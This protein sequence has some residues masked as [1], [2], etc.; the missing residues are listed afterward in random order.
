[1][2]KDVTR[3]GNKVLNHFNDKKQE[4][5]IDDTKLKEYETEVLQAKKVMGNAL[6]ELMLIQKEA[7]KNG[8]TVTI[9]KKSLIVKYL[10]N[11]GLT[12]NHPQCNQTLKSLCSALKNEEENTQQVAT[13]TYVCTLI[14]CEL[15][16]IEDTTTEHLKFSQQAKDVAKGIIWN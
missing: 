8:Q 2:A 7:D 5:M 10:W 12:S 9:L 6:W 16:C 11:R 4:R 14:M 1:M 3:A 15:D 13:A